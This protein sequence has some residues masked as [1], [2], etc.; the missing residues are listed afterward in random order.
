MSSHIQIPIVYSF[1]YKVQTSNTSNSLQ[2][3]TNAFMVSEH[4][5]TTPTLFHVSTK[6][7]FVDPDGTNL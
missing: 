1:C 5:F 4:I 3:E 7:E 2:H 6:I